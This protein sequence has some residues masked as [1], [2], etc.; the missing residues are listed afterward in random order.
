MSTRTAR[1]STELARIAGLSDARVRALLGLLS[2]EG[3]VGDD[4]AG[5]RLRTR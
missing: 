2:L 1:S 3:R 5:W 4:G